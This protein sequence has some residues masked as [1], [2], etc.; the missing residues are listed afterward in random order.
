MGLV[1]T[2][3]LTSHATCHSE[4]TT[5]AS[6]ED[7]STCDIEQKSDNDKGCCDDGVCDCLC[8]GHIFTTKPPTRIS[9]YHPQSTFKHIYNYNDNYLYKGVNHIWQPPQNV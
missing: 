5:N 6:I 9:L 1:K 7:D 4:V 3:S 2:L 8:C